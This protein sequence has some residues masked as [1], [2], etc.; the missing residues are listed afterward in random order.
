MKVTEIIK[1]SSVF[2]TR[3]LGKAFFVSFTIAF[4]LA[5]AQFACASE[6]GA[7]AKLDPLAWRSDLAIW[8][9]VV[10]LLL[11]V[12]LAKFAFGPIVKALDQREQNELAR[13]AA[14]EKANADAKELLEQYRRQLEDSEE[15]VRR[16]L[17]DAKADATEQATAIV[18][19]A[20]RAVADERERAALDIQAAT[21]VAMREIAVKGAQ[22]ATN[23]AGKI[24][25]ERIELDPEK[26]AQLVEVALNDITE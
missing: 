8:T 3:R 17:A 21:D 24:I 12:A 25:Q 7:D 23:L 14:A 18:E 4:C 10:F 20:K 5:C 13:Q 26:S 9:A 2:L 1:K 6:E 11:F 16:M 15:E 22:L 19:D